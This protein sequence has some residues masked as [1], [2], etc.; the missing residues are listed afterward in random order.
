MPS[1]S[2]HPPAPA[3][4]PPPPAADAAIKDAC[5]IVDQQGLNS[6]RYTKTSIIEEV[7][8]PIGESLALEEGWVELAKG[9]LNV[10]AFAN[11]VVIPIL[12]FM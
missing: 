6:K 11:E 3:G 10:A 5:S 4:R 7:Q 1:Q 12:M 2:L 9:V 8:A